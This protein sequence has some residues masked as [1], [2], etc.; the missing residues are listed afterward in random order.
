MYIIYMVMV[1]MLE[2]SRNY[3]FNMQIWSGKLRT[4]TEQTLE[5]PDIGFLITR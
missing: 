4:R 5:N 3:V 1:M 2:R